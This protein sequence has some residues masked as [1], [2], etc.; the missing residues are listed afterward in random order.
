MTRE[1]T[2]H[3]GLRYERTRLEDRGSDRKLSDE[4]IERQGAERGS[5]RL[6]S[7]VDRPK[8]DLDAAESSI[9]T[10]ISDLSKKEITYKGAQR[11]E[12]S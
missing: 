3:C 5:Q 7:E 6:R 8:A 1:S 2:Q 4:V 10:L 12:A 11:L 9:S